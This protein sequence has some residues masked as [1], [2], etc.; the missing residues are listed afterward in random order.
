MSETLD[1]LEVNTLRGERFSDEHHPHL[2]T[3]FQDPRVAATL[4]GVLSEETLSEVMVRN[5]QHWSEHGF[6]IWN[7]FRKADGEF[8]GRCGLRRVTLDNGCREVELSYTVMADLWGRGLATEMSLGVLSAGFE[9]MDFKSIVAFTLPHN[10]A[11][12]R[13]MEKLGFEYERDGLHAGLPHVFYRLSRD[14]F[15]DRFR[16]RKSQ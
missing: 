12:R 6:G 16:G 5:L 1:I 2:R 15:A 4:G 8:V 7:F 13:V 11:S 10:L 3:L 9:L 14:A